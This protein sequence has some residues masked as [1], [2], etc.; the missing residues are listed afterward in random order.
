MRKSC[1]LKSVFILT[2]VIGVLVYIIQYKLDDWVIKPGK[3]FII[4]ESI[5]SI[6]DELI[7][8]NDSANKDSLKSLLKYFLDN[9][10][11]VEEIVNLEEEKFEEE[12]KIALSDSIISDNEI[13][14]LTSILKKVEY[15]KS[16]SN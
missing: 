4:N 8:I 11:S 6:D 7:T 2:V 9:V 13:S 12:L 10:K 14:N 3:K 1:F 15:E 5:E 16:K